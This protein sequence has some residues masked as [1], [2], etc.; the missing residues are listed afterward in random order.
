MIAAFMLE[1]DS[2]RGYAGMA[3][4]PVSKIPPPRAALLFILLAVLIDMITVGIIMPVLLTSFT[5]MAACLALTGLAQSLAAII[6]LRFFSGFPQSN[7]A[8]AQAAVS[9]VIGS[10]LLVS[11]SGLPGN[12][13][14]LGAPFYAASLLLAAAAAL[15]ARR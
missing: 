7:V 4:N 1:A 12:D 9:P 3:E 10:A 11:V 13:W 14:R 2:S 6:A 5:V 8:I 15:A